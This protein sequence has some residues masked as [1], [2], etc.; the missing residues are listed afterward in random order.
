[1]PNSELRLLGHRVW[2]V[3]SELLYDT[4]VNVSGYWLL[5]RESRGRASRMESW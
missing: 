2:E 4:V 3:T 1:M 5:D